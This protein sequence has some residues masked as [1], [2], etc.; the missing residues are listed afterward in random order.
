VQRLYQDALSMAPP[1][2]NTEG[3]KVQHPWLF[4][5]LKAPSPIRPWLKIRMPTFGLT[6]QEAKDIIAYFGSLDK[7]EIP[8]THLQ[9]AAFSP[10]NVEAG[11]ALA[12]KE[13]F[14]C[15]SC[16]VR[17]AENPQGS[18]ADWA[19]D[20]SMA[21]ARL[22]P[23]WIVDWIIDPQKIFPGTKMPSFYPDPNGPDGPPDILG[24]DD[25]AQ[26][27]ALRDYVITLGLPGGPAAPSPGQAANVIS[28]GPGATQ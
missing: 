23:E 15:F 6:D 4:N 14:N 8:F 28:N 19:P 20:L 21:H 2:L 18:P 26:M 13:V 25:E 10:K 24:G 27:K 9:R 1:N 17:G 16:H 3:R 11:R 5:F 12:D 7:V 22:N